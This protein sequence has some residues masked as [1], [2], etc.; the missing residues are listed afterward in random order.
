MEMDVSGTPVTEQLQ[1]HSA[2]L[3]NNHGCWQDGGF[4]EKGGGDVT[5]TSRRLH[6]FYFVPQEQGHYGLG[7]STDNAEKPGL[8]CCIILHPGFCGYPCST[9]EGFFHSNIISTA[10]G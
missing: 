8:P 6:G 3:I 1:V 2:C 9:K 7:S 5:F 4:M 10:Q